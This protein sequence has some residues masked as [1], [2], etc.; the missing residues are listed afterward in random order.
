MTGNLDRDRF[1]YIGV[2]VYI[3]NNNIKNI[4]LTGYFL[5]MD[6]EIKKKSQKGVLVTFILREDFT[7]VQI[8]SI[9]GGSERPVG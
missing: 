2:E 7:K 4:N 3:F 6:K 1:R 8:G 5:E 9:C